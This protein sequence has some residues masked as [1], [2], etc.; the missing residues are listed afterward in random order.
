MNL[1]DITHVFQS[2]IVEGNEWTRNCD[3]CSA[4]WPKPLHA[5]T[6]TLL[7]LILFAECATYN[8]YMDGWTVDGFFLSLNVKSRRRV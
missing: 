7:D 1:G 5:I 2:R 3:S 4:C 8:F 6:S